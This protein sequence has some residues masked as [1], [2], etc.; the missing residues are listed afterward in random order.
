MLLKHRLKTVAWVAG[1][2]YVYGAVVQIG[3]KDP[4]IVQ[5]LTLWGP[6]IHAL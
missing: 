1:S 4:D 2:Q 5:G 3:V 6:S